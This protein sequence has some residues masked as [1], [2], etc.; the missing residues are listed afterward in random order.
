MNNELE[1]LKRAVDLVG[2]QSA[3]AKK[4]GCKQQN[5]WHW[6]HKSKKAAPLYAP[7]I[8]KA[9]GGAVTKEEL[10]PDIFKPDQAA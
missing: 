8:E 2:G 6:L 1:A 5:V 9:T 10:R 7:A 3:L 4:L